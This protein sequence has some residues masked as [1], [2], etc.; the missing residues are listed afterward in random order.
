MEIPES[1]K[2]IVAQS[3]EGNAAGVKTALETSIQQ[4]ITDALATKKIE[5][6]Q[7]LVGVTPSQEPIEVTEEL[8]EANNYH[9]VFV[10]TGDKWAHHFDADNKND[11]HDEVTSLKNQGQKTRVLKVP[12]SDAQWHKKDVHA[13]VTSREKKSI[14]EGKELD[15]KLSNSAIVKKAKSGK[16]IGHGGFGKVEKAAEKEYGSKKAGEKVAAA[17]M[18]KKYGNKK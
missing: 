16:N 15:E 3:F 18:W 17:V 2:D 12:K 1:V 8:D 14:S 6:A 4:K 10:H 11:A 9:S 5:I 7:N 13:Y